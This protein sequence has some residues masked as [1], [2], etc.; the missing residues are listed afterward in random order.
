MNEEHW[1]LVLVQLFDGICLAKKIARTYFC[2]DT[3]NRNQRECR[4]IEH[5][6]QLI[7]QFPIN[8]AIAAVFYES[9]DIIRRDMVI[10]GKASVGR[11]AAGCQARCPCRQRFSGKGRPKERQKKAAPFGGG[12]LKKGGRGIH[13]SI[14]RRCCRWMPMCPTPKTRAANTIQTTRP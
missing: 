14:S 3:G 6:F 4:Q 10:G 2:Y 12:F 11:A 5:L 8:R 1:P 9:F 7:T 13:P